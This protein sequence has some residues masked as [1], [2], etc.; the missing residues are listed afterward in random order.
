[1]TPLKDIVNLLDTTLDIGRI[2]DAPQA[3]NGLQIEND[4]TVTKIAAAVD[5]SQSTI[6]AAV[7]MGADLL[8]L[9]HGI[10]WPGLQP[11]TGWW[12]KKIQTALGNNLAIYSA[13]L[14]LDMHPELGNN[15]CIAHALGLENTHPEITYNGI[16]IGIRG[17]YP[18]TLGELQTQYEEILGSPVTGIISDDL[19]SPAGEIAVCSGGA[20]G[21]I[22]ALHK[23]GIRTYL[24]GETVH[25]AITTAEDMGINLLFGGHYAT[26]T[27]GVQAL[28]ALLERTFG[29]PCT[30][31]DNPT[32]A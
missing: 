10:Y 14:P 21:E 25:W 26:E 19:S 28:G 9:H 6:E 29:L 2:P 13:H 31:I 11:I 8:I 3:M 20:A 18:G 5:G 30:F 1:M 23:L 24:T 15:A 17:T 4:G 16:K 12:K 22:Y 32:G 7:A 27:F